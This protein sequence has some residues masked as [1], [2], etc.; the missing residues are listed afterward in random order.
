MILKDVESLESCWYTNPYDRTIFRERAQAEAYDRGV[1]D[2]LEYLDKLPACLEWISTKDKL[3]D[4]EDWYLC[5][6][7]KEIMSLKFI[8]ESDGFFWVQCGV[9][10]SEPIYLMPDEIDYWAD[11]KTLPIPK[12]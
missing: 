4:E 2:T 6:I 9:Y 1:T 11:Y 7:G 10:I 5:V 8:E 12:E 3:P